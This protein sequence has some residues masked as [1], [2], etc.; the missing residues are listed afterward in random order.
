MSR[1]HSRELSAAQKRIARGIARFEKKGE[2]SFVSDLVTELRLAGEGGLMPTLKIME[3]NGFVTIH[4]GGQHGK[5]RI[6]TLTAKGKFA[7]S[8]GGIPILGSIP[9]GPLEEAIAEYDE[10]V[11][12]HNLLPYKPGDFLL[13]VKKKADSMIGDGIFPNDLVLLRPNIQINSGEIAAVHVGADYEATL[14]HVI[15][16]PGKPNIILRAS[17]PKYKDIVVPNEEVKVAGVYRWHVRHA[18]SNS[19]PV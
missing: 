14:K 16:E 9:A 15:F 10:I 11:E 2:P 18:N 6:V 13:R 8:V 1:L 3:R 5:A 7:A 19:H 4:G 17:N 12:A